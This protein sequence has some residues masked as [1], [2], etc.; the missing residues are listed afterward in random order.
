MNDE[1]LTKLT[2]NM[3]AAMSA[4][5]RHLVDVGLVEPHKLRL[6]IEARRDKAKQLTDAGMSQQEI[7]ATLGVNQST[8]SRDL[9]QDASKSDAGCI[10]DRDERREAASATK[11]SPRKFLDAAREVM[12]AIDLD[13]ASSAEARNRRREPLLTVADDGLQQPWNGRVLGSTRPTAAMR[14]SSSNV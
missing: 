14:A 13:P 2:G 5:V 3:I 10:S 1:K 8:I 12:G 4:Q 9:M 6:T 7:A 11:R